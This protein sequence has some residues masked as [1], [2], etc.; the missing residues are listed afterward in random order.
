MAIGMDLMAQVMV[1]SALATLVVVVLILV[2]LTTQV[3]TLTLVVSMIVVFVRK[4]QGC[5][6]YGISFIF[7]VYRKA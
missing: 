7:T 1:V 4:Q 5:D 2:V 6:Y 3:A